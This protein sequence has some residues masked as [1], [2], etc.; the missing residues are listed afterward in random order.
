MSADEFHEGDLS[1][2]IECR[3]Q[4]IIS[5][6]NLESDAPAVEYLGFGSR[7]LDLIRRGPI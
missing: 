7:L 4:A 6:G 2:E 5:S 1:A 3:N